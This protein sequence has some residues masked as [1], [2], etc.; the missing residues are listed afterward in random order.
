MRLALREKPLGY[1][2]LQRQNTDGGSIH[3]MMS[4]IG[5]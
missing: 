2:L 5:G 1:R 3:G 4:A